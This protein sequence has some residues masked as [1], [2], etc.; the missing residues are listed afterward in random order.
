[1]KY[2]ILARQRGATSLE[3]AILL[4]VATLLILPLSSVNESLTATLRTVKCE[5]AKR[6]GFACGESSGALSDAGGGSE[7]THGDSIAEEDNGASEGGQV[8]DAMEF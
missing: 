1:M 8:G 3:Y 2:S 4:S 6:P 7:G 5:L